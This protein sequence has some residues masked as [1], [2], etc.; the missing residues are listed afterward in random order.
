MSLRQ[1]L[2]LTVTFVLLGTLLLGSMLVY[3][4]SVRKVE[5]E[6]KASI[7]VGGRIARNALHDVAEVYDPRERLELL[8]ADFDGDRHLR[9]T[10][11]GPHMNVIRQSKFSAPVHPAPMWLDRLLSTPPRVVILRLPPQFARL[12][13]IILQTDASNEIAEVWA[14]AK[15]YLMLLVFFCLT[16]LSILYVVL[17]QALKPL[18]ALQRGFSEIGKGDRPQRIQVA[19]P[20]EL[21]E[22]AEGFNDMADRLVGMKDRNARLHEQLEAVQEEERAELARNLHDEV[23]PLLFSVDVDATN[24]VH[25]AE[26]GAKNKDKIKSS[27]E[28]IKSAVSLL[29][30]NVKGILNQLRP[31]GLHALS[32]KN[33]IED[34]TTFW[35]ARNKDL[36]FKLSVPET[37]WGVKIDSAVQSLV[38]ESLSNAMKH[39]KPTLIRITIYENDFRDLIV[40][41]CDNGGGLSPS[42]GGD[43]L[44]VIGMRERAVLL[45]GNLTVED[46]EDPRGVMVRAKL[47]LRDGTKIDTAPKAEKPLE[48][49]NLV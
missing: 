28:A 32:L 23:S 4:H 17:G 26:G 25:L 40:E 47:P 39:S 43:G 34:L 12:G 9:A 20:S 29:K 41:V 18:L 15:I 6:M 31:A 42:G 48:E 3:W 30:R 13:R 27:G 49:E 2:I 22:L 1:R 16:L 14:D 38:R 36:E 35:K 46:I 37:S 44:G 19:G 24:V 21:A 5:I 33:T 8:V 10:F 11:Y 7:E 45:G